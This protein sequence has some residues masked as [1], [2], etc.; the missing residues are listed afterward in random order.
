MLD[1]LFLLTIAGGLCI[2]GQARTIK[3]DEMVR[4][5]ERPDDER[6]SRGHDRDGRL[7]VLDRQLNGD[8]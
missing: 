3:S 8:P 2:K 5:L 7:S 6:G 1:V 4:T